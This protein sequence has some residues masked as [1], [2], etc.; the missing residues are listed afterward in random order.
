MK[1]HSIEID[2]VGDTEIQSGSEWLYVVARGTA[3]FLGK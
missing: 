3:G 2:N 1:I